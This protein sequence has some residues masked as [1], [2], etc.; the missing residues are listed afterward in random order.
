MGWAGIGC[1]LWV[2]VSLA[3][4]CVHP[5]GDAGL[6][7]ARGAGRLELND[8]K[9]PREV[10][11]ILVAKCAD[12]H[13][14]HTRAPFYGHFAPASW[15]ME[16]DI[17]GARKAMNLSTWEGY[18]ADRQETLEAKM[19][20]E[21][22]SHDMPPIQYRAIHWDA[23]TTDADLAAVAAWAHG[24]QTAQTGSA[25]A[26][27][28]DA[29]RGQ[30][31]FEKRC[32][33]CHALDKN[34]QGPM[35]QGVYGRTSGTAAGYAYSDSMKKAAVVWDEKSLDKWLSDPDQFIAGNNMDFLVVKAQERAD[36]I[37]FLRQS[38]H[39]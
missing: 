25:A 3:L 30:A 33:G 10:Q 28:G 16:R 22:K 32:T 23:K 12:C 34:K 37:S 18:S 36:L 15:L 8:S 5:F 9:M 4:G 14:N 35:L 13:S 27:A 24:L 2:V 1:V 39:R 17:V 11:S 6:Y 26:G 38:S 20:Q 7:A 31:V 21:I 29:S 19:V